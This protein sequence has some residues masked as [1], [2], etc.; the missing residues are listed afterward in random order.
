[1]SKEGRW[2][3][4]NTC[5]PEWC[6]GGWYAL[7]FVDEAFRHNV[8]DRLVMARDL[9]QPS[10]DGLL[11][12]DA[13]AVFCNAIPE[14]LSE[15]LD[16][17]P[18]VGGGWRPLPDEFVAA[19]GEAYATGSDKV[20]RDFLLSRTELDRMQVGW[21]GDDPWVYFSA[22][23]KHTQHTVETD[24]LLPEMRETPDGIGNDLAHLVRVEAQ[25]RYAQGSD[26]NIEID[27]N[28]P[29]HRSGSNGFWAQAWVH[30]SDEDLRLTWLHE[31]EETT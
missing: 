28:A 19:W 22:S 14:D 9:H 24:R 13:R 31:E 23:L 8:R 4:C 15:W 10:L 1:M 25:K 21:A 17:K 6:D 12:H 30:L 7:L 5:V 11:F 16:E 29:V 18:S 27:D 20:V 26:D 3:I 2:Y